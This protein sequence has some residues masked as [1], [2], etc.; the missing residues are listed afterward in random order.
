[1]GR[2]RLAATALWAIVAACGSDPAVVTADAPTKPVPDGGVELPVEPVSLTVLHNGVPVP[3]VHA[4][5]LAADSAVIAAADTGSDGAARATMV[6]DG[7]SVTVIDPFGDPVTRGFHDLRTFAGVKVGDHLVVTQDDA[8][9]VTV[10][11][12]VPPFG[13]ADTFNVHTTC[14]AGA[15]TAA[16]G[17]VAVAPS[18][19]IKLAGCRGSADIVVIATTAADPSVR[20]AL[21]HASAAITDGKL[22]DLSNDSYAPLAPVAL[23]YKNLPALAG[24]VTAS[25]VL[26]TGNGA[27]VLPLQNTAP[28]V[29]GVA[30]IALDEPMIGTAVGIVDT[31]LALGGLHHIVD[32]APLSASYMLDA[33]GVLLPDLSGGPSF[34]IATQRVTWREKPATAV[35]DLTIAELRVSKAITPQAPQLQSWRWTVAAPYTTGELQLPRLP[36]DL[37]IWAPGAG[38]AIDVTSLLN[39]SVPGHYDAVR[40]RIHDR[41][42]ALGF[43]AGALGRA[44]VVEARPKVIVD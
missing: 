39:A 8:D 24:M 27:F 43:V 25:H 3:G 5:F 28:I 17:P 36:T 23:G 41:R 38:D 12:T 30:S 33:A 18:G 29:Q 7:G 37:A 16:P 4:Y 9:D 19:P 10:T 21:H 14:G 20:G 2:A 13:T 32:W 44:V 15:I 11:V 31:T 35:P 40:S 26:T 6:L 22:V 34:S 42:G 1:M